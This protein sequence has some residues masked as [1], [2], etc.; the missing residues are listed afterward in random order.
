MQAKQDQGT[1][2]K[3]FKSKYINIWKSES[4]V[5][6]LCPTLCDPTDCS[7]PGSSVHGHVQVRILEWVAALLQ[8][9][10]PT[11]GSNLG[12]LH[13]QAD[14]LWLSHQGSL[15]QTR[16]CADMS[17]N[18]PR[19]REFQLRGHSGADLEGM[20]PDVAVA[21]R[22]RDNSWCIFTEPARPRRPSR[23][24]FYNQPPGGWTAPRPFS[25]SEEI[26]LQSV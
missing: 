6:Q 26:S 9:I 16:I 25:F 10:L 12:L 24:L 13:Q 14:S 8:G 18:S 1:C 4:E 11:Q 19:G 21:L 20:S 17:L 22:R 15:I 23:C 2:L 5:A 7:P 3:S